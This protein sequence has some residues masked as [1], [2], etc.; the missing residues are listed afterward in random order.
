[1]VWEIGG[2]IFVNFN[3]LGDVMG[4]MFEK[5]SVIYLFFFVLCDLKDDGEFCEIKVKVNGVLCNVDVLFCKGY[6]LLK[7]YILCQGIEK[8]LIIVQDVIV[9]QVGGDFDFYVVVLF[10]IVLGVKVYV[11]VFFE[12]IGLS[13]FENYEGEVMLVEIYGYV[14]DE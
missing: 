6:F 10:F 11:F 13:F 2:E 1:M 14:I 4:Q 8:Q 9:G 7:V 12:V 5:M 3:N